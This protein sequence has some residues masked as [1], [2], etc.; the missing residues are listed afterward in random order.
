MGVQ[1]V[2]GMV[3]LV[4][5]LGYA[6]CL[7][8][9]A[10]KKKEAMREE[11]GAFW[12]ISLCEAIVYFFTTMGVPDFI[13]NTLLF[14]KFSWVRDQY[15][16]GTLVA[17]A[18]FPSA[19]IA[20]SYLRNGE[21]LGFATLFLCM[22]AIA[23][24]S[25]AGARVMTSLSG[26]TIR[27]IM[28]IAM[29]LSMGA[30]VLKMVVSAGT[31]GTASSLTPWQ[32]GIALPVVFFLGFINMFGV[33]MKPPAIALFL[34]LGMSPMSTLTLMLVLGV[35]SPMVG[36]IRVVRSGMYQQKIALSGI[37]FGLLGALLGTAFTVTLDATALGVILLIIMA[38]T[39]VSMLRPPKQDT[40]QE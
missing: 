10:W 28:G 30:L 12:K 34:L 6:L 3:I 24:G 4:Y 22:A 27:K 35:I 2:L 33:P 40:V 20:F 5:G 19:L 13:L 26:E 29:L 31:V 9:Q 32:L 18:V 15:L 11:K 21:P 14:R 37:S 8:I 25:F 16:P 38:L 1:R 23:A 36:G 39:A 7:C 17:T